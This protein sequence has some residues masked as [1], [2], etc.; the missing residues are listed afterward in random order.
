MVE[1]R[2]VADLSLVTTLVVA[3]YV[4]QLQV[5]PECKSVRTWFIFFPRLILVNKQK[6][7]TSFLTMEMQKIHQ[8]L[9]IVVL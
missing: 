4:H 1:L 3:D 8:L 6:N 2:P 5:R 9:K 7:R